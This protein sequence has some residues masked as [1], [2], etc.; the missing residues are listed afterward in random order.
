MVGDPIVTPLAHAAHFTEKI[1]QLPHCY[2]PNDARRA[3]PAATSRAAAGLPDDAIVLCGFH[4]SFKIS[5]AVFARW[6]ELLQRMPQ[7]VLWLLEW[8]ANVR[9]S[10]L[11]AAVA[12][13]IAPERLC[14]APLLP[15]EQHL[16]RLACADVFLDAW[17]CNAHTTAG[18]ALW[19][20]VPVV[21]LVGETFAQR[22]GASLLHQV[23]MDELV[24]EHEAGYVESVAALAADAPRRAALRERLER[25]RTTSPLFDGERFA[26][27]FESL[28]ERL[29]ARACAG[30]APEHLPA[31][32]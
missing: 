29:W 4:Q 6:C 21:T 13:G 15:L 16:A 5:Q 11:A 18:E 32:N 3:R 31:G 10:L 9:E 12:H 7:A 17:P 26:R 23:G 2:Q 28:C 24:C 19:M 14:F 1:A 25:E 8:N 27:D 22:V 20:G 30:L